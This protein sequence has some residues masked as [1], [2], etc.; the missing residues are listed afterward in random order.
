[1][2]CG[3]HGLRPYSLSKLLPSL[4]KR[5]HRS[6][7]LRCGRNEKMDRG[8]WG[9]SQNPGPGQ[10]GDSGDNSEWTQARESRRGSGSDPKLTLAITV[11]PLT[12]HPPAHWSQTVTRA[13][14]IGGTLTSIAAFTQSHSGRVPMPLG[15]LLMD[16]QELEMPSLVAQ[17]HCW[18]GGNTDSR[19][20]LGPEYQVQTELPS[21]EIH[22]AFP[23]W[24]SQASASL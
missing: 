24:G 18:G 8:Q 21:T 5:H 19:A 10:G 22:L 2:L 12:H 16:P 14:D 17:D 1:M 4:G 9:C 3:S 11:C 23:S 6:L 7:R 13:P 15:L 20:F